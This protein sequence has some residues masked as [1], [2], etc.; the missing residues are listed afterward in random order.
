MSDKNLCWTS[1]RGDRWATLD[2]HYRPM[3]NGVN[4]VLDCWMVGRKH[5]TRRRTFFYGRTIGRREATAAAEKWC[6]LR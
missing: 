1:R 6:G 4:W 5:E 2:W 3:G